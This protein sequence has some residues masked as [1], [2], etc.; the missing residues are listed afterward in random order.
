MLV[1]V[2]LGY[3]VRSC[4]VFNKIAQLGVIVIN[5]ADKI[6]SVKKTFLKMYGLGIEIVSARD[7]LADDE[8]V[9]KH[10]RNG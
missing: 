2:L 9:V 7:G 8:V 1:L 10:V 3:L 5:I 4:P 6:K